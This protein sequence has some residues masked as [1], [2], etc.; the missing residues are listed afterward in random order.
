[1]LT[2]A[3]GVGGIANKPRNLQQLTELSISRGV[4]RNFITFKPAQKINN[5]LAEKT[6]SAI[7]FSAV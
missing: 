4:M 3:K 2:R 6:L 7:G 5:A 1:M